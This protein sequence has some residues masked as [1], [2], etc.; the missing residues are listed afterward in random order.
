MLV[1]IA[2][3]EEGILL[4][5]TISLYTKNLLADFATTS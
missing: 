5:L 2:N 3:K 1:E 4:F